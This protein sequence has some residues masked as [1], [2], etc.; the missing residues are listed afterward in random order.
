MI[1]FEKY[2]N[3]IIKLIN[4]NNCSE[5]YGYLVDWDIKTGM[6]KLDRPIISMNRMIADAADTFHRIIK[7][8]YKPDLGSTMTVAAATLYKN[9]GGEHIAYFNLKDYIFV[10]MYENTLLS[11]KIV[12]KDV[13]KVNVKKQFEEYIEYFYNTMQDFVDDIN[14]I[15]TEVSEANEEVPNEL[16]ENT[17]EDIVNNINNKE[18]K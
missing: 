13:H 17:V 14:M 9:E 2:K 12:N 4:G 7:Y 1:K 3:T 15:T 11:D 5:V 8:E 16:E 6:L 18:D 10:P